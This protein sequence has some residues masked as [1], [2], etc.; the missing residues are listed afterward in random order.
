M[1]L[2]AV[3]EKLLKMHPARA[4]LFRSPRQGHVM[5]T[6]P[7]VFFAIG[8]AVLIELSGPARAE[9]S[10][11]LV[12]YVAGGDCPALGSTEQCVNESGDV[13]INDGGWKRLQNNLEVKEIVATTTF[14]LR[15]VVN[16][17]GNAPVNE[18]LYVL[19]S[20]DYDSE[21]VRVG[22]VFLSRNKDDTSFPDTTI[23]KGDYQDF[24][25]GT[26]EGGDTVINW[27][28]LP[29]SFNTL[30][31]EERK[32]VFALSKRDREDEDRSPHA[33]IYTF[34]SDRLS[35]IPF[36]FDWQQGISTVDIVAIELSRKSRQDDVVRRLKLSE[37]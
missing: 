7:T 35:C 36:D 30:L 21:S 26:S 9:C 25:S 19:V 2:R 8:I 37:E 3:F 22:D 34:S 17:T 6:H 29:N 24:H 15:Y 16:R 32:K 11:G 14:D 28:A 18:A 31:P 13:L 5:R 27:H 10:S 33:R 4:E 12:E 20:K 23:G 1:L